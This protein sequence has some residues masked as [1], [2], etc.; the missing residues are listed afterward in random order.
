MHIQLGPMTP[1][2]VAH[3]QRGPVWAQMG[4]DF[5][6]KLREIRA[7]KTLTVDSNKRI[8]LPDAKPEQVFSYEYDGSGVVTLTRVKGGRQGVATPKLIRKGGRTYLVSE[9]KIS[10]E[11]VQRALEDF[12]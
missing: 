11:D 1:A 5:P 9:R 7:V 12:P 6:V 10:S 8:R 3:L 2:R 4:F